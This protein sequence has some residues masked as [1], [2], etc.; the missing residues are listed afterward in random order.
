MQGHAAANLVPV[1]A[2]NRI[3][4]ESSVSDEAWRITF[5]GSSFICDET[6]AMLHVADRSSEAVLVQ[7]FDLDTVRARRSAWGVFR[8]RRP[9]QYRALLTSDGAAS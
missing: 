7:T 2:S 1:I 5:Y 6:G 4:V 8:D 9:S 3:G